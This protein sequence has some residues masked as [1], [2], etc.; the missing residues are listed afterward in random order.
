MQ[1]PLKE[2]AGSKDYCSAVRKQESSN[3]VCL[4]DYKPNF[5]AEIG[6]SYQPINDE[7][8]MDHMDVIP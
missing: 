8:V 6:D 5:S 1:F 7:M 2:F 4:N 3:K